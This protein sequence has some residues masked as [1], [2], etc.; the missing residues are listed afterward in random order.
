MTDQLY[1]QTCWDGPRKVSTK[2]ITE[3]M[4]YAYRRGGCAALAKEL[5]ELIPGSRPVLFCDYPPDDDEDAHDAWGHVGVLLPGEEILD[6]GGIGTYDEPGW[7]HVY[8]PE[9]IDL[10]ILVGDCPPQDPHAVRVT[11][12]LLVRTVGIRL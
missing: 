9:Y 7:Q 3:D 11:A 1:V 6:I 8:V 12:E 5:I 2:E 10:E 4:V